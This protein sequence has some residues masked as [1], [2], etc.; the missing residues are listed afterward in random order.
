M[1]NISTKMKIIYIAIAVVLVVLM[2]IGTVLILKSVNG[3][4][5]SDTNKTQTPTAS[6]KE[7][8]DKQ[9]VEAVQSL[10][11]DPTK[12]KEVLLQLKQKYKDM[13]DTNGM[14]NVDAQL[15]LLDHPK[16]TK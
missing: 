15:Y 13:G 10:H 12:A 8:A 4:K 16:T 3:S 7:T 9:M 1:Q 2:A 14:I 11:N 6:A 5:T